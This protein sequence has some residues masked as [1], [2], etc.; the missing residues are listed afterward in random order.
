MNRRAEYIKH[1]TWKESNA[2]VIMEIIAYG[3]PD[4]DR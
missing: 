3:S 1:F 4:D 2:I